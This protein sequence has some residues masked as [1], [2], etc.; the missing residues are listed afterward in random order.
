MS[1]VP[2]ISLTA[3]SVSKTNIFIP[4]IVPHQKYS[5]S[6]TKITHRTAPPSRHKPCPRGRRKRDETYRIPIIY[7]GMHQ[8]YGL[9]ES[10]QRLFLFRSF[11]Q[12]RAWVR[13]S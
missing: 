2:K 12:L 3:A 1:F 4:P 5:V 11:Y 10:R 6:G 13:R 7:R 8:F 9:L